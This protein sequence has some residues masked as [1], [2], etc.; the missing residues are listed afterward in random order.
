MPNGGQSSGDEGEK[1]LKSLT[2]G[3]PEYTEGILFGR[4]LTSTDS[5]FCGL[6]FRILWINAGE[7]LQNVAG[8]SL[9]TRPLLS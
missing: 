5:F 3:K 2:K 6:F 1:N 7:G 4:R 9:T 8:A